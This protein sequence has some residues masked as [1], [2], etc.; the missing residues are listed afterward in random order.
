MDNTTIVS[1]IPVSQNF[2]P[3]VITP[4]Q[5]MLGAGQLPIPNIMPYG[6][7]WGDF[8]PLGETQSKNGI[9]P[10]SCPAGGT[11]NAIEALGQKKFNQKVVSFQNNLSERYLSI[12]MGMNGNGGSPHVAAESIRNFA[13]CIPEVF[14]PFDETINSLTKYFSP[15]PITYAL[16]KYGYSWKNKY[17]FKHQWL[18]YGTEELAYKQTAIKRALLGSPV[19]VSGY[20]WSLHSDGKY[21][22]DGPDIHW[23]IVFDYVEGEYWLAYDTYAPYVKKLDWNYNFG[24][25]KGYT[26]DKK[27]GGE[28]VNI[29]VPQSAILPYL[30]YRFNRLFNIHE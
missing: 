10:Q 25:A 9:D 21:Y 13:G 26:L 24:Y 6:H 12:V 3:P 30:K 28:S 11:L 5:Y 8:L 7:G 14:L 22:H 27:L 15:N 16:F 17:D 20:A 19:G 18:F 2:I 1:N 23:F 29:D 4:D